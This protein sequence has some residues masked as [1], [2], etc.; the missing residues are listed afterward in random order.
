M[1]SST[2][3]RIKKKI[4][5]VYP[6]RN[7]PTLLQVEQLKKE[8]LIL[9]AQR[10]KLPFTTPSL[11]G[12]KLEIL[13]EEINNITSI[14]YSFIQKQI[15]RRL[16]YNSLSIS[17]LKQLANERELKVSGK[18]KGGMI[19]SILD[20]PVPLPF[21]PDPDQKIAIDRRYDKELII[22]AG[23]GSGKTSTLCSILSKTYNDRP[24]ER[25]IILVYNKNAEKILISRLK[26]LHCKIIPKQKV[27]DSAY[28]GVA[29]LTFDKFG[30]QAT[31]T[32]GKCSKYV[33]KSS[34]RLSLET[35]SNNIIYTKPSWNGIYLDEA[36]DMTEVH[37]KIV[38]SIIAAN[39]IPGNTEKIR[40]CMAGDPRQELYNGATFFSHKWRDSPDK[41]KHILHYNHR[42]SYSVVN[43][44]NIY[45]R[46]NF[47][48]LH[49]DQIATRE[50]EGKFVILIEEDES[51][52]GVLIGNLLSESEPGKAYALAPVSIDKFG[53]CITTTVARQVI[54]ELRPG[55]LVNIFGDYTPLSY[56]IA[57]SK[58]MKGTERDTVVVY[59]VDYD[60]SVIIDE[61]M[62]KKLIYVALSRAQDNLYIVTKLSSNSKIKARLE[63]LM[64]YVGIRTLPVK[65]EIQVAPSFSIEVAGS[66]GSGLDTGLSTCEDIVLDI[67]SKDKTQGFN[68]PT[69]CG[70]D[71][72]GHYAEALI[73]KALGCELFTCDNITIVKSSNYQIIG[74]YR[75]HNGY[76]VEIPGSSL[77]KVY[78]LLQKCKLLN[79]KGVEGAAFIHATLK[80]SFIILK[81]WTVAKDLLDIASISCE[82]S[83]IIANYIKIIF[84]N[85]N[86]HNIKDNKTIKDINSFIYS[87]CYREPLHF[88][89]GK[90]TDLPAGYINYIPDIMSIY[91]I[92]IKHVAKL[93]DCH[94]RQA[95][96]YACLTRC[97]ISMLINS[98][99]GSVEYIVASDYAS[100]INNA[101]AI[102]TLRLARQQV[103]G[104]LSCRAIRPARNLIHSCV[105]AVD[106]ECE[107]LPTEITELSAIAFSVV[108][109]TILGVY[110]KRPSCVREM[111]S[112][113]IDNISTETDDFASDKCGATQNLT[114]LVITQRNKLAFQTKT[115]LKDFDYWVNSISSQRS[116]LHWGGSEKAL[117]KHLG[118][119]HDLQNEVFR[120]WLDI[121]GYPRNNL[122]SLS[123]A[124]SQV[125]PHFRFYPH[126]ALED[127]YATMAV[128][129]ATT[130]FEGAT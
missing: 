48:S 31:L 27:Y 116:I 12:M 1:L 9:I 74:P 18:T 22:N 5:V 90:T 92:E 79:Y 17:Q 84:A 114:G 87:P 129:L 81:L 38:L 28:K 78:T 109:F 47:R 70:A 33:N 71:F 10:R 124:A 69:L 123:R 85:L 30:Y 45:S 42:S 106:I 101:R 95:A 8:D 89:R 98:R 67:L 113:E 72:A 110:D 64:C 88:K 61:V 107:G 120:P 86:N 11:W 15:K 26:A 82:Q 13:K 21:V 65:E 4:V 52:K 46:A 126:R 39:I 122:V 14:E 127:A 112:V 35:A 73:V 40:L 111:T 105:I 55:V 41:N 75:I 19:D 128:F 7:A 97:S 58:K 103:L 125:V 23:P 102:L 66:T 6:N 49:H 50:Y 96:I 63:T 99:D 62:M 130:S 36:Q 16:I 115:L 20:T 44:L 60:Y 117:F 91:P 93:T 119:T 77:N 56:D 108:D 76:V 118:P 25:L 24:Q 51:K 34:Y 32:S 121:G 59:A 68:L 29:V 2:T 94:R 53:V 83:N 80:Y 57:T 3:K 43:A 104:P 54:S 100:T 37:K